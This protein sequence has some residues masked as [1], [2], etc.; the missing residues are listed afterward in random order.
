ML[1]TNFALKKTLVI[2]IDEI[3]DEIHKFPFPVQ[4]MLINEF[5]L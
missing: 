3:L 4:Q 1:L 5:L 2:G